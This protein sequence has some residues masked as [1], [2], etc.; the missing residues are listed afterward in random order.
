[1]IDLT[2]KNANILVVDDQ[3]ANIDIITDLLEML[4]YLSIKT[5]TDPRRVVNMY[6]DFKPDLILLDLMMPHLS[7]FQVM[8]QLK[9]LIPENTY[10]PILVLTADVSAES[11][12]RALAGGAKDFLTK[13]FDLIEVSLR[14]KNLLETRYLHLQLQNQ[15][16]VL[17]EK[18][19]ERTFQLEKANE[20]LKL[21]DMAK[22]DFLSIISHEINTPLNGIIGFI[23]ILKEDLK[24]S[25]FY[26]KFR[27]LEI[28]AKRLER[29]ARA[30]LLITELKTRKRTIT[31]EDTPVDYLIESTWQK[32]NEEIASKGIR[33]KTEGEVNHSRININRELINFCFESILKNAVKFSPVDGIIT[34][35]INSDGKQTTCSF[36]DQ[37]N[38]FSPVA[39]KNLFNLFAPGEQHLDSN[40]GLDLALVKFIMDAHNGEILVENN[41]PNGAM[42]KLVFPQ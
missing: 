31:K 10:M 33:L 12:E 42:V 19:K 11:K 5:T 24:N 34:M 18:V 30:S 26:E 25:E 28:S 21:L 40:K 22:S 37:G 4:G 7:G 27:Y 15:N 2:L 16:Q 29:F 6:N 3:Q 23:E 36:I 9:S 13:P 17:E 14:I 38:G 20:E 39:M 8:E 1:M 35:K 41:N 32:L